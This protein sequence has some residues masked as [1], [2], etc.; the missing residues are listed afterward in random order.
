MWFYSDL[1]NMVKSFSTDVTCVKRLINDSKIWNT[2]VSV[3]W[4][5]TYTNWVQITRWLLYLYNYIDN[6]I[7]ICN[8]L[9]FWEVKFRIKIQ[10]SRVTTLAAGF[11]LLAAGRRLEPVT[12]CQ[13]PDT[14][15]RQQ[16]AGSK[17]GWHLLAAASCRREILA[18]VEAHQSEDATPRTL[19]YIAWRETRKLKPWTLLAAP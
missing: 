1:I 10:G 18:N 8:L 19:T 5:L 2:G 14:R 11:S 6:Y 16:A 12:I 7:G 15:S 13:K 3:F 4:F 17:D 9:S